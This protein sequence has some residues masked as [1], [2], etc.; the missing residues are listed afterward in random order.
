M[1][2]FGLGEIL[3]NLEAAQQG[4]LAGRG[5]QRLA[6]AED[7]GGAKGAIGRGSVIGVRPRRAAGG[8]DLSSLVAYAV[9]KRARASPSASGGVRWRG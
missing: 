3:Y 2:L 5:R 1:G 4:A 7:L 8:G 9:E 6:L